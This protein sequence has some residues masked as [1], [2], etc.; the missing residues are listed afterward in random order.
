MKNKKQ[1]LRQLRL[2]LGAAV[3]AAAF[4]A[5]CES[6]DAQQRRWIFQPSK[7]AWWGGLQA[8]KGMQDVWIDFR[9]RETGEP[10]RLHGLWHPAPDSRAPVLLYLHG[11]RWDVSGSAPRVRR[12]QQLGFSVLAVDYR[13]FG[14]ST[15]ALPSEAT[16]YEDAREAWQW[17]AAQ[18]PRSKRYIFGHSLG[19]AIAVHLAAGVDDAAGLIVEGSF[20][21]IAAVVGSFKWGWLP[22]SGF[23]TQRFDAAQ[24]I[25]RVKVP[26]LVVHGSADRLIAPKLGQAL[27]ERAPGPKRWIEVEGG[28]HHSTNAIGQA[29]YREALGELFGLGATSISA[30]D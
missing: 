13:G 4:A 6:L 26:V 24:S 27:F 2:P 12:M 10:V 30:G 19:A 9:S 25:E 22:V 29:M 7:E 20:P 17:L 28:S 11:A 5:G 16:A 23:I 8:A 15:D 14:K 3:L 21:S 1:W 18:H